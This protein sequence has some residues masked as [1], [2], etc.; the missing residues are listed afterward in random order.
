[1]K[2]LYCLLIISLVSGLP[3]RAQ[4]PGA[5]YTSGIGGGGALFSPS[6][7]PVNP[8]EVYMSCDMGEVFHSTDQGFTWHDVPFQQLQGGDD[9]CVE[10]Q[11]NDPLVRYCVDYSSVQGTDYIRPMK[12]TDGGATW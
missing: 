8:D 10:F 12:S 3:S 5:W 9:A 11:T 1:M 7:N 6:I 4:I 2:S